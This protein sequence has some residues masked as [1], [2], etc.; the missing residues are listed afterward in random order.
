MPAAAPFGSLVL[1]LVGVALVLQ[2]LAVQAADRSPQMRVLLHEG[3]RL[4]LRADGDQTIHI[5]G[6]PGGDRQVRRLELSRQD[7]G[8]QAV[9]DG[10][11]LWLSSATLLRA[12]NA[13]PRGIWLGQRRYRGELQL[14]GR[15]GR[16]R[17][18]NALPI[19]T[20][21]ASVVGSEMPQAW[22]MAALQAQA[23]AARTYAF[24]Q[25]GR[26]GGWDLKATVSSQV[27]RGVESET[28]RTR[29]AVDSTR[30][31]VLVHGGKLID[32]VFHSSSGGVTEASGMV[33]RHQL[34]YL[35]SVPDH[36]Q[37]SPVHR[38]E[39]RFSP[40]QL[41]KRLPETGGIKG[42]D[43]LARSGS[44]RVQRARIRGPQGVLL[45]EGAELRRRLG[46]KSTLVNFELVTGVHALMPP[47]PLPLLVPSSRP[48]RSRLDRLT[49]SVAR[50]TPVPSPSEPSRQLL[51]APPP[52]LMRS[53]FRRPQGLQGPPGPMLLVRGQG[54]GHGVGMSQWGAH[55]LAE[56][57]ADFRTILRHYYRGA[58]VVS[59]GTIRNPSLAL[60]PSPKP[61]WKG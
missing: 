61:R 32:A 11:P 17:V 53:G 15:G 49:A 5:R 55:G 16:L 7:G 26:G 1:R 37:H 14:S 12:A 42:V 28:P 51:V 52:R 8:L 31:L 44:G 50:S 58:E 47:P 20:Y 2:P 29:E 59:F 34:P 36:D 30:T 57:G 38:W 19:E 18:I 6:L 21:L 13:D 39:E 35:V 9:V 40:A 24:R 48:G 54:Y 60:M 25:R 4:L 43:V 23:V 22:P 10:R 33:W 45:L 56:Q 46:L 27:Y 3:P 41:R